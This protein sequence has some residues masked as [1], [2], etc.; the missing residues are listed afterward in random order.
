MFMLVHVSVII[1]G[2]SLYSISLKWGLNTIAVTGITLKG[3]R[4]MWGGGTNLMFVIS[5]YD[6]HH[7]QPKEM[8]CLSSTSLP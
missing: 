5:A 7:D 8:G 3:V 4:R 2:L 6:V 1:P